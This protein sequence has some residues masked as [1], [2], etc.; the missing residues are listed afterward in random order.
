MESGDDEA[1]RGRPRA[2]GS[3]GRGA[4]GCGAGSGRRPG[5]APTCGRPAPRTTGRHGSTS[6]SS[7]SRYAS[8]YFGHSARSSRSPRRNFQRSSGL[9][10]RS[11]RRARCSSDEMCRNSLTIVV[12]SSPSMALEVP[13]VVDSAAPPRRRDEALDPHDEDVLVVAAVEHAD[14][15]AARAGLVDPPQVVVLGLLLGGHPEAAH[16]HAGR[17]DARHHRRGS[18]RPCRRRPWPAAP[19]ARPAAA[20]RRGASAA[21]RAPPSRRRARPWRPPSPSRTSRRRGH[22]KGRAGQRPASASRSCRRPGHGAGRYLPSPSRFPDRPVEMANVRARA[23]DRRH[24]TKGR[25]V[26]LWRSS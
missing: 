2:R 19:R 1:G 12:P 24:A 10:M 21:R 3:G 23:R 11:C 9:S 15:A 4:R 17:V 13:D 22:Q 5:C 20:R 8:M 7:A 18:R 16:R 25:N 6:R 14:D 26:R